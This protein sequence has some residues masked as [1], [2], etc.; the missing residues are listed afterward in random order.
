MLELKL[1]GITFKC[2][3]GKISLMELL[4]KDTGG[5]VNE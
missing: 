1:I 3:S 2:D 4:L 5:F